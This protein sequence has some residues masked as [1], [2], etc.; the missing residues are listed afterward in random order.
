M[1]CLLRIRKQSD[2]TI[3]ALGDHRCLESLDAPTGRGTKSSCTCDL[4][5]E[6]AGRDDATV[7]GEQLLHV[8]LAHGF[9]E[10]AHIKVGVSNGG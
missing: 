4:V 3:L 1:I 5:H 7:L 9:G 10:S 8:F 2:V 6:D